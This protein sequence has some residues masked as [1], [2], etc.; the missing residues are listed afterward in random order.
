MTFNYHQGKYNRNTSQRKSGIMELN[1]NDTILTQ[2]KLLTQ[3]MDELEK[4]LSKLPQQLK[5]MYEVKQQRK[6]TF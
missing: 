3:T 5:E 6:I 4:Q 1:T 2:N